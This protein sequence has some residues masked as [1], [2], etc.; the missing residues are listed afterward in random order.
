MIT[1]ASAE[2]FPL[3]DLVADS[4]L[5]VLN[6]SRARRSSAAASAL[7]GPDQRTYTQALGL[8][9][10]MQ[11]EDSLDQAIH[12]LESLLLNARDSAVVNETLGKALLRKYVVS[13]NR[14]LIDQAA[15]YAERAVL[16]DPDAADA[17]VTLG[18]LRRA[19]GRLP[20]ARMEFQRALTLEPQSVDARLGM[21]DTLDQ[22]GQPAEAD[23]LYRAAMLL[24][25]DYPDVY[26]RY[27]RFCYAHGRFEEAARYFTKQTE[28]LPDAPRG[29]AN[30]GVAL[31]ALQ[32]YDQAIH[33]YQHSIDLRPTGAAY[34]NLGSLQLYLGKYAEAAASYE[35]A[36][37]LTPKN[38]VYWAN[39]G[40]AYRW[41]PAQRKKSAAS[42]DQAIRLLRDAITVN[43]NDAASRALLASCLAKRGDLPAAQMELDM[44]LKTDPTNS[45][46]LY[47]AAVVANLRGDHDGAFGWLA[48]AIASGRPAADASRDP[49]LGN[50]RNDPR[51][52]KA[53]STPKTKS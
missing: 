6:V 23:R 27:G 49:E 18:E 37:A 10:R 48:R 2:V 31:Q 20:D 47:Q 22:L 52:Q 16:L 19:N 21:A 8:L 43:P 13:R 29:Y 7:S 14:G 50:L 24:S 38:H 5:Q 40:D 30:L 41:S 53:L 25:P 9:Q 28:I 12:S 3:E 11:S 44:A 32:H 17:H 4:V 1:T 46:A 39:L 34:S 26:G 35:K 36:A 45:S 15:V 42:Y 51:F 33:A